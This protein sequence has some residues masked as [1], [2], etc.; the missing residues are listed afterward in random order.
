MQC[1]FVGNYY[2]SP[3]EQSYLTA[4]VLFLLLH[5]DVDNTT[6]NCQPAG[7]GKKDARCLRIIHAKPLI[8]AVHTYISEA[9]YPLLTGCR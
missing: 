4:T 9:F 3:F 8:R 2:S 1:S 6:I 7:F 5:I